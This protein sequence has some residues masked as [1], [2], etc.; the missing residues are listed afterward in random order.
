MLSCN[1]F[2]VLVLSFK[3]LNPLK[4]NKLCFFS[5]YQ[6]TFSTSYHKMYGSFTHINQFSNSLDTYSS[7]QF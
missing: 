3:F 7:I 2:I 4:E 6:F 5:I 1:H